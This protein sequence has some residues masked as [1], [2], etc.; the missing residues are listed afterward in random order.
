LVWSREQDADGAIATAV[1]GTC[2]QT[3]ATH[4]IPQRE[5]RMVKVTCGQKRIGT[6]EP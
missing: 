5:L 4:D 6:N 3:A 1:N 2:Y